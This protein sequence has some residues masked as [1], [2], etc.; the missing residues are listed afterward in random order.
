MFEV[1][2]DNKEPRVE[3]FRAGGEVDQCLKLYLDNQ[4]PGKSVST[5]VE[6]R[7]CSR[8]RQ[9]NERRGNLGNVFI[10]WYQA[11]QCSK[12]LC[13]FMPHFATT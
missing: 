6:V 13:T 12:F 1:Y 3:D 2:W 7:Q 10:L 5:L 4:P 9:D 11:L 8:C